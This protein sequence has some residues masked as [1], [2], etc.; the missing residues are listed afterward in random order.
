MH[1]ATLK[2]AFLYINLCVFILTETDPVDF[3]LRNH[4]FVITWNKFLLR[5][6][7]PH[8]MQFVHIP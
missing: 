2:I 7:E 8:L 1:G 4:E 3:G 6:I 5:N